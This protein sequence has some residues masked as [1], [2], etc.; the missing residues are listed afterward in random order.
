MEC[1]LELLEAPVKYILILRPCDESFR[2]MPH[3][4]NTSLI[5]GL[6]PLPCDN[7]VCI[8]I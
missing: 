6:R 1:Q 2:M 5:I 3:N 4:E 7:Y 8:Y